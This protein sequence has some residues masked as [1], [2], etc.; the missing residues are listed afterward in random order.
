MG[1]ASGDAAWGDQDAAAIRGLRLLLHGVLPLVASLLRRQRA[2]GRSAN[3]DPL[4]SLIV[5]EGEVEAILMVLDRDLAQPVPSADSATMA[6]TGELPG[7]VGRVVHRFAVDRVGEIA[8]ALAL[9]VEFDSRF[10]RLVGYLND[11]PSHVRPTLGL[12]WDIADLPLGESRMAMLQSPVVRDGVLEV[13]GEGPWSTRELQIAADFLPR[14]VG[15]PGPVSSV[16]V[17]EPGAAREPI[18]LDDEAQL[19]IS[20]WRE[21]ARQGALLPLLLEGPA[22]SGR[23]NLARFL[24]GSL[25]CATVSGAEDPRILRR[26][27]R[28]QGAGIAAVPRGD[29]AAWW[30]ILADF[31]RPIAVV[32]S[33]EQ[34]E[35]LRPLIPIEPVTLRLGVPDVAVRARLWRASAVGER[36]NS[37][38]AS[39]IAACFPFTPGRINRAAERAAREPWAEESLARIC[40]EVAANSFEGFA[41][42]LPRVFRREDLVLPEKLEQEFALALAWVSYRQQVFSEWK[43]GHRLAE[44]RGL[45][46]LLAGPPGTGKTMAAQVLARELELDIFRVDLSRVVSKY[47]GET[48][49]HLGMLL[50]AAQQSGAVLLFDEADALFGKRSEVRD[51]RDRYANIEVGFLLQRIEEHDGIVLLSTN[52]MGDIDEAFQRRFQ[53]VLHFPF[54]DSALRTRIWERL[55]PREACD[56][57]IDVAELAD[58]FRLCGGEIRNA[59]LAAAFIAASEN[60]RIGHG[61]LF[62]ALR[63][64]VLKAGRVLRTEEREDAEGAVNGRRGRASGSKS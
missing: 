53:F 19:A 17:T 8:L 45:T 56:E 35:D 4:S 33:P 49:K 16:R 12:V 5:E 55:L 64:E 51:A 47:I 59:I 30:A 10:A 60:T 11:H 13:T 24:F 32:A 61:H 6:R 21:S 1:A 38:A 57:E 28:L 42:R 37:E 63:R 22:G 2:R 3:S 18:D 29:L 48:E 7:F 31:R 9:G 27:A 39:R 34:G 43:L 44:F 41:R 54:P 36:L 40:R 20:A 52:R 25:G 14:F 46:L 23:T 50:A 26:E 58:R 15:A 62:S